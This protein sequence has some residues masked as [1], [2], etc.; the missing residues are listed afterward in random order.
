MSLFRTKS[1]LKLLWTAKLNVFLW[2]CNGLDNKNNTLGNCPPTKRSEGK[3]AGNWVTEM[4]IQRLC[5]H[6]WNTL[7]SSTQVQSPL[8][9]T[10][11]LSHRRAS[12]HAAH[13]EKW[14]DKTRPHG[15]AFCDS[16]RSY[17]VI[18]TR[19]KICKRADRYE[20]RAVRMSPSLVRSSW[21]TS[22][23][24]LCVAWGVSAL[25]LRRN[26]NSAH[27]MCCNVSGHSCVDGMESDFP[28]STVDGLRK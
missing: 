10:G 1:I 6:Q 20:D 2:R 25:L 3:R 7:P 5:V 14:K 21:V 9:I 12:D 8:R 19:Q 28:D 23:T 13:M 24:P 4:S 16:G 17:S 27:Y 26:V 22:G 15:S 11:F 18:K